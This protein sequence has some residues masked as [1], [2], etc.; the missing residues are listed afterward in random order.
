MQH[1]LTMKASKEVPFG[2]LLFMRT[3]FGMTTILGKRSL[4]RWE[5][6]LRNPQNVSKNM[7]FKVITALFSKN[8][9]F[10]RGYVKNPNDIFLGTKLG[11]SL[12][13]IIEVK[14]GKK[15]EL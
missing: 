11:H 8:K 7:H 15:N 5:E 14:N 4:K 13:R 12:S 6:I 2:A 10:L 1:I 9:V 3:I